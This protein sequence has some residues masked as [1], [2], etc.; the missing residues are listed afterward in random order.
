MQLGHELDRAGRCL[1][2]LVVQGFYLDGVNAHDGVRQT[3]LVGLTCRGNG[4]SGIS[5]GGASQVSLQAC[6]AGDNGA[7]QVRGESWSTTH[8]INCNLL[9]KSAPAIVR[10]GAH[11]RIERIAPQ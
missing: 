7:A 1:R 2:E 6:L 3:S 9:D 10:D 8:I 11:A 4:R 5:I